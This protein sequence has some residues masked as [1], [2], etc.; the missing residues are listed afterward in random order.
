MTERGRWKSPKMRKRRLN[1]HRKEQP[2]PLPVLAA[3]PPQPEGAGGAVAPT[4]LG[5]GARCPSE[6]QPPY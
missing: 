2:A 5:E 3:R 1:H 6:G 4:K